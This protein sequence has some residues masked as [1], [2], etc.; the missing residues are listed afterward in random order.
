[1][2][3]AELAWT[4]PAAVTAD[5]TVYV[6]WLDDAGTLV[7]QHDG[8]PAAGRRPVSTW[9]PGEVILD[10]HGARVPEGWQGRIHIVVGWYN[11]VSGE[12]IGPP[13]E[14]GTIGVPGLPES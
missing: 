4:A 2:V 14:L 9:Q 7:A 5:Y 1:V 11:P 10:R 13:I 12:Q 8:A 6:H 3:A